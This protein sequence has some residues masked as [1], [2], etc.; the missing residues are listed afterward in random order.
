MGSGEE[1][2]SLLP[3]EGVLG[4]SFIPGEEP[5][6]LCLEG[7]PDLS[8]SPGEDPDLL[9]LDGVLGKPSFG[10][11]DAELLR[12]LEGVLG[13]ASRT[14]EETL[15]FE[16][17]PAFSIASGDNSE[18]LRLEDLVDCSFTSRDGSV[19]SG[20]RKGPLKSSLTSGENPAFISV[21]GPEFLNSK[22]DPKLFSLP[23]E[24][25][26]SLCSGENCGP[27]QDEATA[28]ISTVSK[29]ACD[30]LWSRAKDAGLSSTSGDNPKLLPATSLRSGDKWGRTW[31]EGS[32]D[33]SV[34]SINSSS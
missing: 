7:V 11:E 6:R 21:T 15:W 2:H 5:D 18:L 32:S 33:F 26:G 31:M 28:G 24:L 12:S 27:P 13:T 30:W 23:G 34:T 1:S 10:S 9:L 22:G 17:I 19:S 3:L 4:A 14:G 29:A 20:L 16:D 25:D 8:L